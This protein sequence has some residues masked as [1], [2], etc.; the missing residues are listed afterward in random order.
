M[1]N[2]TFRQ[3]RSLLAIEARGKIVEA[4]KVV[5]LTAPAVTL[6]LKQLEG[7]VGVRLFDRMAH[8]MY[9]TEAGHAVLAAARDVE[10]RLRQLDEEISAFKGARRERLAVGAVSTLKYIANPIFAAF[11]REFPD[12]DIDV[13]VD[14]RAATVDRL[15]NRAIDIALVGR[16]P[17]DISVRA[18]MF[19]EQALVIVS[20]PAHALVGRSGITKA[21]LAREHFIVRT[22]GSSMRFFFERFMS[23]APGRGGASNTEMESIEDIK[24][25]VMADVGLAFVAVHS[26]A[27]EVQAGKLAV[28]DVVGLP[29]RRQWF[30]IS[31]TDRVL[32]P[33]MAAFQDFLTRQS[34][35]FLMDVE[36]L[37]R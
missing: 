27:K 6:Q 35:K 13:F 16:P 11:S 24:Q 31:R 2:I 20:T 30:A 7:E 17:R 33:V 34:A 19:G 28:L 3:L 15:R 25:A 5:G 37:P 12:I 18:A 22:P 14:R 4:A 26:V 21:E 23:D 10:D 9:P 8:G 29:I 36:T 32:T 1:K